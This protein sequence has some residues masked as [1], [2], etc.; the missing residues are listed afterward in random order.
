MVAGLGVRRSGPCSEAFRAA[1][2]LALVLALA[3]AGCSGKA[4]VVGGERPRSGPGGDDPEGPGGPNGGVPPVDVALVEDCPPSPEERQA[5]LGCWPP[6]HLGRWRGF[7]TGDPWYATLDGGAAEFPT[8]DVLLDLGNDGAG[9]MIFGAP[10]TGWAATDAPLAPCSEPYAAPDC[11]ELGLLIAGF[12]YRLETVELFDRELGKEPRIAGEEPPLIGERMSF[13]VRV[14][15]P[16]DVWC[17][18]KE[19]AKGA[20][21]GG[22][23]P[24]GKPWPAAPAAPDSSGD[25]DGDDPA[26]CRCSETGCQPYAPSLFIELSMSVDADAL[27]GSYT[28]TDV[29]IAPARL[30]FVRDSEP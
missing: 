17:A 29:S 26:G 12:S 30:E 6:P 24:G 15:E 4:F 5:L 9:H 25:G 1:H 13:Q 27:R 19:P 3:L 8:G 18:L 14:G 22:D 28:P 16:W 20:C 11:N 2:H 7:F 21:T 23:C 10:Q